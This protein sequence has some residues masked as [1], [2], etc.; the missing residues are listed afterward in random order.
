MTKATA[1]EIVEELTTAI[2][3]GGYEMC[4]KHRF[5]HLLDYLEYFFGDATYHKQDIP[6]MLEVRAVAYDWRKQR[7]DATGGAAGIGEI[8]RRVEALIPALP[9]ELPPPTNV[10]TYAINPR[11]HFNIS[12]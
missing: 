9:D 10:K 2:R 8:L 12:R 3:R 4:S 11:E 6:K 5:G 7:I 1:L